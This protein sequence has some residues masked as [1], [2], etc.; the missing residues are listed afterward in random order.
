MYVSTAYYSRRLV[1]GNQTVTK[2]ARC[3]SCR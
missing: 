3:K 1:V 2:I